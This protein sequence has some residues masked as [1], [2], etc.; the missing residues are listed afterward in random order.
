MA[1]RFKHKLEETSDFVYSV[2]MVPGRGLEQKDFAVLESFA[3]GAMASKKV[4]V[5]S[6]TDNPGGNPR[7]SPDYIARQLSK[8]DGPTALVHVACK[9]MNRAWLE[10]RLF[11]LE[12]IGIDSILALTGDYPVPGYLGMP[13]PVFDLDSVS[14]LRLIKEMNA[15]LPVPSRKPGVENRL[16]PT[17]FF[18]GASTSAFKRDPGELMWQYAKLQRKVDNGAK[19]IYLQVGYNARKFHE[20]M[21]YS[22]LRGITVPFIGNVFVL[23]PVVSRMMNENQLPGCVV[24]DNLLA[25]VKEWAKEPDKGKSKCLQFAAK[26]VAVF[27]GLGYR[28]A[29]IGGFGLTFADVTKVMNESEAIADQWQSFLP[30]MMFEQPGE[31]YLFKKDTSTGLNSTEWNPQVHK[32]T[33][34][35]VSFIGMRILHGLIFSKKSPFFYPS[36]AISQ[37]LD[38]RKGLGSA[39]ASCEHTIKFFTNGCHNCAD[40]ALP[41]TAY[42]CPEEGCAKGLRNGPCGGSYLGKCEAFP[43]RDCFWVRVYN[44]KKSFS[45]F[46]AEFKMQ[47]PPRNWSLYKTSSWVNYFTGKDNQKLK[48]E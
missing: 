26:Q 5:L 15:G 4:D 35:Q 20:L 10:S 37:F 13:K 43:E 29:H 47:M 23:H 21:Q 44:R 40:C 1:N 38:K 32:K 30:E 2:E 48:V 14:L 25:L 28:G 6:F 41:A 34:K 24:P 17:H 9:D 27:R 33:R 22:K 11:Q 18:A 31:F 19:F 16:A 3:E 12:K 8:E 39:V 7:L 46:D 36:R 42:L 45:E